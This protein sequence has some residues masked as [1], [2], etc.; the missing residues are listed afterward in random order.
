MGVFADHTFL[1]ERVLPIGEVVAE[2]MGPERKKLEQRAPKQNRKSTWKEK[3]GER[4]EAGVRGSSTFT[5]TLL[6]S[7]LKQQGRNIKSREF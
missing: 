3:G 2:G 7:L 6:I 1:G 4:Q 5:C